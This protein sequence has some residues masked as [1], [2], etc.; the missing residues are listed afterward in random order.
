MKTLAQNIFEVTD[1]VEFTSDIDF[2]ESNN[3]NYQEFNE[4]YNDLKESNYFN[5][6]PEI[7]KAYESLYQV[8]KNL[9]NLY[10]DLNKENLNQI[11]NCQFV[12]YDF[13]IL[14]NELNDSV[15]KK[16]S[17][18]SLI[19]IV[20]DLVSVLCIF[21]GIIIASKFKVHKK[22]IVKG[23]QGSTVKII[24]HKDANMDASSDNLR[25]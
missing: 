3:D 17:L 9:K 15:A 8:M 16:L 19:I 24:R 6:N 18:F 21:L 5:N 14:V 23:N 1:L 22:S 12:K 13:Y 2:D 11:F 25:K 10:D 7:E 20:V 4:K